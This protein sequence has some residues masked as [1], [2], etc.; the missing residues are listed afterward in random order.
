LISEDGYQNAFA[1]VDEHTN[2]TNTLSPALPPAG[3]PPVSSGRQRPRPYRVSQWT[4]ET[5]APPLLW[6]PDLA[7]IPNIEVTGV[8][9]GISDHGLAWRIKGNAYVAQ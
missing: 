4:F 3:A 5:T 2:S 8:S 9:L 6:E 7:A 1:V